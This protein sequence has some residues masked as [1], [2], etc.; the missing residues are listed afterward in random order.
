MTC[1]MNGTVP[2]SAIHD[3]MTDLTL[4]ATAIGMGASLV[5]VGVEDS[6]FRAPDQAVTRNV[7]LVQKLTQRF[8][9]L[10]HEVATPPETRAILEIRRI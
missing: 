7:E 3:G 8:R 9:L 4:L 10:G 6:I 1:L 5:R 2:W